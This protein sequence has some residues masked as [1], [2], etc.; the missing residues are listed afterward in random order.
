VLTESKEVEIV[1]EG[2]VANKQSPVESNQA[3]E[4]S[5]LTLEI[6]KEAFEKSI[7]LFEDV[8]GAKD[9]TISA[10]QER[11]AVPRCSNLMSSTEF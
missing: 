4:E 10:I 1:A 8:S 2:E 3:L 11:K 7:K 6:S 5:D 9:V